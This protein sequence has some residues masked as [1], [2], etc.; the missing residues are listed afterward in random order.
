[1]SVRVLNSHLEYIRVFI[2]LI[3]DSCST[4]LDG[5]AEQH[6]IISEGWSHE[7]HDQGL[8]FA[9]QLSLQ[10]IDQILSWR[11]IMYFN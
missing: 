3:S 5:V 10:V 4:Y 1:M 2:S 11:H 7:S 6:H 9:T 8:K